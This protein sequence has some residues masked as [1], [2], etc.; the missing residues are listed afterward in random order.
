MECESWLRYGHGSGRGCVGFGPE[1]TWEPEWKRIAF[2]ENISGCEGGLRNTHPGLRTTRQADAA[3]TRYFLASRP[4]A[5][6]S[7]PASRAARVTLPS[8]FSII[9]WT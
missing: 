3:R 9:C 2:K 1:R 6:R 5:R 4:N 8:F 7:L